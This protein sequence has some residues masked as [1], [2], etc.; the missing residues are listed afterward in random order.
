MP[1]RTPEDFGLS[2]DYA[3]EDHAQIFKELVQR[4]LDQEN[5]ELR[6]GTLYNFFY[7][8]SSWVLPVND[9]LLIDFLGLFGSDDQLRILRDLKRLGGDKGSF[10]IDVD[11]GLKRL[12]LTIH[13]GKARARAMQTLA[14]CIESF[15]GTRRT[16]VCV[17]ADTIA[18]GEDEDAMARMA[19][20]VLRRRHL[21]SAG[22]TPDELAMELRGRLGS[23]ES[24]SDS[25]KDVVIDC[26]RRLARLHADKPKCPRRETV[27][28]RESPKPRR[29]SFAPAVLP[30][31]RSPPLS[32]S[33]ILNSP[34]IE[35]SAAL[36]C[37]QCHDSLDDGVLLPCIKMVMCQSCYRR[38]KLHD[39]EYCRPDRPRPPSEIINVIDLTFAM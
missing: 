36:L 26:S 28:L 39:C 23:M 16:A 9:K 27:P 32:L 11:V 3:R 33:R 38:Q 19:W 5:D 20:V 13:G 8:N 21:R 10:R 17:L 31:S 18:L 15:E 1:R 22:F 24:V 34:D 14:P 2:F 4:M 30:T 25:A 7:S 37:M 6:R 12:L 29:R 35:M